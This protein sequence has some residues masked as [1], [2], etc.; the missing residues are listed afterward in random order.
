MSIHYCANCRVT[1]RDW[2]QLSLKEG[3]TVFRDQ[4]ETYFS[5][6]EASVIIKFLVLAQILKSWTPCDRNFHLIWEA[7]Q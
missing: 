4:V 6:P 2:F 3:L 5:I 1:C 7:V